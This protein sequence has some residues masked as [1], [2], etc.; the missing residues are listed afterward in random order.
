MALRKRFF[1]WF[2]EF[3]EIIGRGGFD[4]ILGNP[5]YLGGQGLSGTYGQAFC[6]FVKWEYAPAGLSD[7]VAY[8]V[9][10]IYALLRPGGFTA[11]ITTNSIKDGDI[12]KDGLE[13]VL[14]QGGAINMAVRGIKWPGLAKLVVSLVALHKG[15]WRGKRMLDGKDVPVISA[16]FEDSLDAGEPKALPENSNSVY[17]GSIFRGDGFLLTHEEAADLIT[18]D[19]K[20][21]DAIRQIVNGQEVNN[22]P[23]QKPQ[24]STIDFFDWPESKSAQY[25]TLFSIVEE[26]VKP[27]RLSLDDKTA[28]NRDH[29]DRWWQYA[30]VRESLYDKIRQK[31][32]C[33]IAARTTKYLN[34]SAAPTNYVFTDALYVFTTDRYDLYAVVQSTLHEV[35]ARKYS[36]AL[37]QDLRY[38]PSKCFDTFPFPEGLWQTANLTLADLGERYHEHR[39]TLMRQLWLGLTDIYNLFHTRDLTPAQV[40]KVSK[41]S[42]EEAEAGY[43]GIL[44][45][46]RLHR[47]LDIAIRDAYGWPDLNL[48]HDF[49][50][51]ETLPENDRVR[52]TI[53]PTARK[54]V[55]KRLLAEN[56]RRAAA[57]ATAAAMLAPAK[58][59]RTKKVKTAAPMEDLFDMDIAVSAPPAATVKTGQTGLSGLA[60][61]AWERPGADQLNEVTAVLAAVLKANGSP[62]PKRDIRLASVLTLQPR[63]LIPSLSADEAAQ[64]RRLIGNEGESLAADVKALQPPADHFWG[65]AVRGLLGRGRMV[66]DSAAQTWAPGEGLDTYLTEG[67]PEGRVG[68]VLRVLRQRGPEKVVESLSEEFR[69]WLSVRAA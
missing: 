22:E 16:Y 44:E 23:D 50:E 49:I 3:P 24:R 21:R 40:A 69:E 4:C 51:V 63:L 9:R 5:P 13:Q 29:R 42:V 32:H 57:E 25:D 67:W 53:S 30:F 54:E 31:E 66:E 39:R 38:S 52:Y 15:E 18:S 20:N 14:A 6:E 7:L 26:K 62:M 41:K 59:T 61:G 35:W 28:I 36:G 37:K 33:F 68:M 48:G 64:W 11:F 8:F 34:F 58:K 55:L 47:E 12:R 45:L 19:P 65:N 60:D 27:V 2:L 1:H 46:R 56:H 10:R 43:Q 17:Q